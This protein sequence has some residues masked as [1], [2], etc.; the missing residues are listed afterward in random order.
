MSGKIMGANYDDLAK[1]MG[2]D[3][4]VLGDAVVGEVKTGS[5]FYAGS[6]TLLTGS[7]TKTLNPANENVP[8]GYYAA[9]T[10]SAVDA[11]LAAGNIKSGV[12]I[13]GKVGSTDVRDVSDADA[14]VTDVKTGKTF[15]AVGGA[16]KTGTRWVSID[17][18]LGDNI[19]HAHDAI[20]QSPASTN[21]IL[22]K[23][24]KLWNLIG[25]KT[26]RTSFAFAPYGSTHH[27]WAQIRKNGV[28]HGTERYLTQAGV[29]QTYVEDLS[30]TTDDLYQIYIKSEDA[31][32]NNVTETKEMRI[33]SSTAVI[34]ENQI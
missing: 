5:K 19:L 3:L 12:T 13:F 20:K 9:T 17:A 8:A 27:S 21:W 33:K 34:F 30:F 26:L 24:I 4:I 18:T 15:Y 22:N 23:Q 6:T 10:L 25:V 2:A 28:I 31:Y 1:L 7:G 14:L 16:R 11:D 29:F 32:S